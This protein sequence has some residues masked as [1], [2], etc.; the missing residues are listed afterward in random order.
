M[1]IYPFK[2]TNQNVPSNS[3]LIAETSAI[4]GEIITTYF[5]TPDGNTQKVTDWKNDKAVDVS[6][7][8]IHNLTGNPTIIRYHA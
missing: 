4:S 3:F 8:E 5:T 2:T 1:K 7:E 6:L